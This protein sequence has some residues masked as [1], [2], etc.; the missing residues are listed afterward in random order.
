[1][2][3]LDIQNNNT[4]E[5][6]RTVV[7]GTTQIFIARTLT[8]IFS[9]LCGILVIRMLPPSEYGLV[10]IAM[11]LPNIFYLLRPSVDTAV[12][13]YVAEYRSKSDYER[14]FSTIETGLFFV[15]VWGLTLSLISYS[16]AYPFA[17]FALNKP[18]VAPLIQI[19]SFSIVAWMCVYFTQAS[20][21]GQDATKEYSSFIVF[22]EIF[23][24]A[25]PLLLVIFGLGAYGV[26]VGNVC[27]YLS[28]GLYGLLI[29][30]LLAKR[31]VKTKKN[32]AHKLSLDKELLKKLLLYGTPLGIAGV[33]SSGADRYL[34]FLIAAYCSPTQIGYLGAAERIAM[35][36]GFL[37]HPIQVMILPSFSKIDASNGRTI[38]SL[39]KYFI[40]YLAV[41]VIP[42]ATIMIALREQIVIFL[43]GKKYQESAVYLL[44]LALAWF[45]I[46]LGRIP[47]TGLLMAQGDTSYLM[48][49][50]GLSAITM[51]CLGTLL[52]P[53]FGIP[54]FLIAYIISIPDIP[55]LI[56]RGKTNYGVRIPLSD[57]AK[58]YFSAIPLFCVA[59][60][61]ALIPSIDYITKLFLGALLGFGAYLLFILLLRC[62][63]RED[64]ENLMMLFPEHP[65]ISSILSKIVKFFPT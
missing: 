28:A 11:V 3:K 33:I 62:I 36:I 64:I 23:A 59:Y 42:I 18:Y 45:R 51:I 16:A 54:G 27:A 14:M 58:T 21:L 57:I 49:T 56:K 39:F 40:K 19:A 9:F 10:P 1:M 6:A 52:I 7:R 26:V 31:M 41:I 5:I 53:L 32:N 55:F 2:K 4:Y 44:L 8:R 47:L 60:L 61:I 38:N 13:K 65:V 17:T 12:T 50:T 29:V 63:K 25:L 43:Y 35:S 24:A 20:L 22:V 34:R 46:G 48:M 30:T 37:I 15:V